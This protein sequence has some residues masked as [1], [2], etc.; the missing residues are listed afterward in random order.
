MKSVAVIGAGAWGTALGLTLARKG[1]EVKIYGRD[2]EKIA[3]LQTKREHPAFENLPI[4]EKNLIF[5]ADA[6]YALSGVSALIAA[7]PVQHF[8]GAFTPFTAITPKNIPIVQTAKGMEISSESLTDAMTR[9]VFPDHPV[10]LLSGP[11]FALDLANRLPTAVTVASEDI[12]QARAVAEL[13]FGSSL[14]PYLSEDVIGVA[15]GGAL[16]NVL[17]LAAGVTIGYGLGES[18]KAALLARGFQEM[19]RFGLS[20]GGKLETLCG[21][22]GMGDLT[23]TAGSS[24]SRN[25]S[26]GYTTG[27]ADKN[28]T[29]RPETGGKTI[30]GLFTAC[31]VTRAALKEKIPLPALESVCKLFYENQNVPDIL[32]EMFERPVK[33]EINLI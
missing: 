24:L 21:L 9:S 4:T 11:S 12:K 2:P 27:A 25:F 5:T 29:P 7:V 17:A 20:K 1:A 18:A 6:E 28:H 19:I 8:R 13:F 23:L 26:F 32:K 22:S 33:N 3:A 10:V 14:R 30:E 15:V 31:A 16:K